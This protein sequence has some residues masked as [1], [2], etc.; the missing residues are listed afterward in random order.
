MRSG[1]DTSQDKWTSR[2]SWKRSS[3][4]AI[5]QS[6]IALGTGAAWLYSTVAILIPDLSYAVV[7]A[8]T[9]LMIACPCAIG[10][11]IPLSLVAGVGKAAAHGVLIRNGEALQLASQLQVIVLDKT[12]TVTKGKPA[13]TDVVSVS[14]MNTSELLSLAAGADR[15]SEHPLA[16]A[17][18]EGARQRGLDPVEPSTFQ[19]VPGY[20][21]EAVVASH[22][23]LVGNAKLLERHKVD[24]SPLEAVVSR[25]PE[26]ET[27]AIEFT[28]QEAGEIPFQCQMGMLRG[29][30]IVREG[31]VS[32]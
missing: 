30:I 16:Q 13:L 27:V 3:P 28:P 5:G 4:P 21:I 15:P 18:V 1:S 20:G 26:G 6:L 7:T 24:P 31:G 23:V 2:P 8:V 22:M 29:K 10:M 11:A 19:A 12:G 17:I 14:D 25:L 32:P 9:V